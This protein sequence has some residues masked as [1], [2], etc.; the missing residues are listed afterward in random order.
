MPSNA[1]LLVVDDEPMILDLMTST[2]EAEGFET[3]RAT[4]GEDA[5]CLLENEAVD[6]ANRF[7]SEQTHSYVNAVLDRAAR[8]WKLAGAEGPDA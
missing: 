2:L 3:H 8:A 6:L 4:N 7:G 5:I 1:R